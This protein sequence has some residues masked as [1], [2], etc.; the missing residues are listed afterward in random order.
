MERDGFEVSKNSLPLRR[1][2]LERR[3]LGCDAF[4]QSILSPADWAYQQEVAQASAP[5]IN[6]ATGKG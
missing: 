3:D 1:H 6:P 4:L 5:S 2:T